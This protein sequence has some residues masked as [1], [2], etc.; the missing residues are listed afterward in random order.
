MTSNPKLK[1]LYLDAE[2]EDGYLRDQNVFG[3]GIS[4]ED[5]IG[6]LVKY[7]NNTILTYSLNA[8]TPYEG[9]KI[10]FNGT[11]GRIEA[12]SI[13]ETNKFTKDESFHDGKTNKSEIK[14]FPMF[15]NSYN[16]NFEIK[17]G[18]H[19]GGDPVLLEDL[20]GTKLDDP[21]NRSASHYD[22]LISILTGIA[23]NKSIITGLPININ[24]LLKF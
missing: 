13:E 8:Y 2:H 11:L 9:Y 16:V 24:S 22:G 3:D 14:V 10:S 4:I 23:A 20:F 5:T 6:V 1:E 17:E 15:G 19:G 18:G 12:L 7:K 21:L